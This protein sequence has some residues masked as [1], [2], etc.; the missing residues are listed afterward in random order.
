MSFF[1][2]K[3][4]SSSGISDSIKNEGKIISLVFQKDK[5]SQQLQFKDSLLLL[6][7]SL[8]KLTKAFNTS[9]SKDLFPVKFNNIEHFGEVP[10]IEYFNNINEREYLNYVN[11]FKN[12]WSFKKESI[13]YCE[14]DCISLY[15]IL[16][17]FNQLIFDNFKININK[18][19]TLPGLS[20]ANF[21]TNF[22]T[23]ITEEIPVILGEVHSELRK[24]YTGSQVNMYLPF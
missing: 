4:L 10:S 19:L 22:L 23:N 16:T 24:G 1:L 6:N 11:A 5:Y 20:F 18:Y 9:V 14:K 17:K 12:N 3:P 2:L 8:K 21:R 15:Q 13:K 7:S